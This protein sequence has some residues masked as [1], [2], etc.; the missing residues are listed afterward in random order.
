MSVPPQGVGPRGTLPLGL[1][2]ID[3]SPFASRH[4]ERACRAT[5]RPPALGPRALRQAPELP[6]SELP[7]WE[8]FDGLDSEQEPEPEPATVEPHRSAQ[9]WGDVAPAP[10]AP[11]LPAPMRLR[12]HGFAPSFARPAGSRASGRV[13]AGALLTMLGA[14]AVIAL[15][16]TLHAP[17]ERELRPELELHAAQRLPAPS[18]PEPAPPA[19]LTPRPASAPTSTA[20]A[21]STARAAST[22]LAAST[23]RPARPA[24]PAIP[25]TSDIVDP[26]RHK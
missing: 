2:P 26:W 3:S 19:V 14:V 9:G 6:E 17:H 15:A 13:A 24:T 18:P 16:M 21:A 22:A 4:T 7:D 12:G 25:I 20:L 11:A 8:C 10:R 23:A 5:A 1:G